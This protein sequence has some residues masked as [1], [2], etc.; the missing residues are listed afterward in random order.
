MT[1]ELTAIEASHLRIALDMRMERIDL[2]VFD[3]QRDLDNGVC[4]SPTVTEELIK[5]YCGERDALL[6][7]SEKLAI[8]RGWANYVPL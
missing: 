3:W 8:A 4:A 2:M 6:Q 7:V 5:G 1:L